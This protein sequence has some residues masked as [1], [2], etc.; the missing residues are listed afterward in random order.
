GRTGGL[1]RVS[2]AHGEGDPRDPRRRRARRRRAHARAVRRQEVTVDVAIVGGGAA[3][4]LAAI[5]AAERGRRVV[6]LER[7]KKPGVKILM[8]G[9]TRCNITHDGPVDDVARA[10]GKRG[11]RFLGPSLRAFG[12]REVM[13][14]FEKADVA[15]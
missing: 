14:F 12:P 10:F 7:N 8:S 11:G 2:R 5:R 13:A 9:G 1:S 15:V 6:L 3:G 4:L